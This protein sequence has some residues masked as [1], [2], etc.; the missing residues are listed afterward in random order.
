MLAAGSIRLIAG[1]SRAPLCQGRSALAAVITPSSAASASIGRQEIRRPQISSLEKA[2]F[3]KA[4]STVGA[5]AAASRHPIT[6]KKS[7]SDQI[8]RRRYQS[9]ARQTEPDQ[10]QQPAKS[11]PAAGGPEINKD[12]IEEGK[13]AATAVVKKTADGEDPLRLNTASEKDDK[14]QRETDWSI[15]KKLLTHIWPKGDRGTKTRVVL[16]LGLLIGGKVSEL[17]RAA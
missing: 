15:I 4:F 9:Y 14:Q 6:T 1:P 8:R 16:A 7:A 12:A 13:T 17:S 11:S 2:T 3:Q 10:K 5:A